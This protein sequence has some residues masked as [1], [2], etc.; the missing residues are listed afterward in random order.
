[1]ETSNLISSIILKLKLAYPSY[2]STLLDEE[3]VAL[4]QMYKDELGK[5]SETTLNTSVRN[6]IRKCKYMPSL[7]ELIDECEANKTH[8]YN[9]IIER[10][11]ND[12]YFKTSQELDK[13][14]KFIDDNTIP[15]WLMEDMKNYATK[16]LTGNR[17]RI[18][19]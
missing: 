5:Y 7:K 18:E 2:F 11:K 16:E 1:M 17:L 19:G 13:A 15:N 6:A 8:K 3:L 10:M 14:L 12:G 4:A 9:L